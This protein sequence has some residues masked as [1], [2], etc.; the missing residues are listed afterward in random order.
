MKNWITLCSVILILAAIGCAEPILIAPVIT[1]DRPTQLGQPEY[2]SAL[3]LF[4]KSQRDLGHIAG[5][6][7]AVVKNNR[8]DFLRGYGW[9]NLLPVVN[10]VEPDTVWVDAKQTRFML[11]EL[12]Y[13]MI[14]MAALK[15]KDLGLLDLD[16]DINTYLPTSVSVLNPAYATTPI[17]MRMLLGGTSSLLDNATVTTITPNPLADYKTTVEGYVADAGNYDAAQQ[18]GVMPPVPAEQNHGA[19]AVAAYLIQQISHISINDFHKAHFYTD[20]GVYTTSWY[21][22]EIPDSIVSR[23]YK[24]DLATMTYYSPASPYQ[25]NMYAP[26]TMRSGA[27]LLGR[28]LI[29]IL[30][31]GRFKNLRIFDSLTM[32]DMNS[33]QY[34]MASI[35]QVMGWSK[36]TVNG[37]NLIGIDGSDVGVTNRMYYDEATKIGV[38][39]LSNSDNCDVEIDAILD[40]AFELSE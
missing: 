7:V 19:M 10:Q 36:K 18:P 40:K 9:Y 29:P 37:R 27:E 35:S 13:P 25:Y 1:D 12:T 34:P 26:Y 23:H 4:I 16:A 8:L 14:T 17:S 15:L 33:L 28:Y 3:D 31:D 2:S 22:D 24:N 32:L 20:F 38:I 39:I 6:Q 5:L 21:L 11:A 30:N